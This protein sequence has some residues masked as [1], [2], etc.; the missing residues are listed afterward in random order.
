MQKY[1]FL[2]LIRELAQ[3]Y[4]AFE[5]YSALNHRDM[6]LTSCQFD[7]IATLG[8]TPGMSFRELGRK[9]LITKGTLTG[10]V[11][12]LAAKDLVVR[13]PDPNDRRSQIV[14]LTGQGQALFETVFPQQLEYLDRAFAAL[15]NEEIEQMQRSLSRLRSIFRLQEPK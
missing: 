9:T 6:G 4:Q 8:N 2:P 15:K 14:S 11:D 7:I 5:A 3:C 10:V 13:T 1:T 12:R